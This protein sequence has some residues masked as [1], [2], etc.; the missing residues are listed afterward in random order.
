MRIAQKITQE[1]L[2]F[3]PGMH[4]A[5][6]EDIRPTD[7]QARLEEIK[8]AYSVLS[9]NEIRQRYYSL[10]AVEWGAFPVDMAKL[11]IHAAAQSAVSASSPQGDMANMAA[12]DPFGGGSGKAITLPDDT[13]LLPPESLGARAQQSELSQWE[14]FALRRLGK[15]NP[16]SFE[17]R[18]LPPELAFEIS[19]GLLAADNESAVKTVFAEAREALAVSVG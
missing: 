5:E 18:A 12:A 4:V 15:S 9:I 1:L 10:P 19:A 11:G 13:P 7:T 16:R 3:W 8:T 14:R 2:P 6:F 17:V